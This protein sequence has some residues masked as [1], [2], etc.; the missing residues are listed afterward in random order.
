LSIILIMRI[1]RFL[2]VLLLFVGF[3]SPILVAQNEMFKQ[4]K[5]RKKMWKRSKNR[6]K[7]REAYNPYLERKAKNKPSARMARGE[8]KEL[9]RQKRL[10]KKQ[11]KRGKKAVND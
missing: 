8:K 3:S 7:N 11:M 5:E 9:R 4:K 2:V 10:A 1:I 6:R